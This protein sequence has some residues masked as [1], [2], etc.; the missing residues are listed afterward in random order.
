MTF[1]LED[2]GMK[3]IF[4]S[5][6]LPIAAC[7][8]L[9]MLT[10]TA[11]A[12]V[13]PNWIE[14][15]GIRWTF[16]KNLSL[17][18][19]GDTYQYG[20]FVNGDYWV[21]GP[22]NIISIS[23]E[24]V[25]LSEDTPCP[26]IPT[27]TMSA[28]RSINGSMLNPD[29]GGSQGYDSDAGGY[30]AE[31]NVAL[32]VSESTPLSITTGSLVS[33]V[34]RVSTNEGS[35]AARVWKASVL[36]VVSEAPATGSFRPPY[37]GSDKTS[38]FNED[39]LDYSLLSNLQPVSGTP[40]LADLA[41]DFKKL[42]LD[43]KNGWST[44]QIH[45]KENMPTY[46]RELSNKVGVAALALHTR[47]NEDDEQSNALKRDLMIGFV[48]YGIDSFGLISNGGKSLWIADGGHGA[49]RKW[50]ILFAGLVLNDADMMA[51]GEKSGSYRY[52]GE[53]GPGNLPPDFVNFQEDDT[54]FYV[55]ESDVYEPPYEFYYTHTKY[56]NH[57]SVIVTNGSNVV[58][59]VNTSWTAD[60]LE[61]RLYFAVR[62][63]P[64]VG[65]SM[66]ALLGTDPEGS[67][68]DCRGG[69]DFR[70]IGYD[71]DN[72]QLFLG[73]ES[74]NPKNFDGY[75]GEYTEY[76]ISEHVIFG[77]GDISKRH[78]FVEF[79][80]DDVGIPYWGIRY[81][82]DP[83][84]AGRQWDRSYIWIGKS[85]AGYVL[86]ARIMNAAVNVKY[87][88]T[89]QQLWN[90]DA[91][92]DYLDRYMTYLDGDYV[93]GSKWVFDM[94]DA[95]RGDYGPIWPET[96]G[97][98]TVQHNLGVEYD[99]QRGTVTPDSGQYPTGS[100]VVL[101]AQANDGY[102]FVGWGGDE[103][104]IEPSVTITMDEDKTILAL[105]EPIEYAPVAQQLA[106]LPLTEAVN[107][108][109]SDLSVNMHTATAE[110]NVT[111]ESGMGARFDGSD[112]YLRV[113]DADSLGM[114]EPMTISVW[115]CPMGPTPYAK[116]IVK[117][118]AAY[119]SPWEMYAI[120][121]GS[122]GDTPRFVVTDGIAGG[123]IVIAA[124]RNVKL[125]TGQWHHLVAVY[126]GQSIALYL[127][128]SLVAQES[129]PF[130]IGTNHE[131][132]CIG[133]RMGLNT[134]NGYICDVEIYQGA[135][136]PEQVSGTFS[137]DRNGGLA[138]HWLFERPYMAEVANETGGQPAQLIGE[139]EWGEG[140]A[141]EYFVRLNSGKQAV[142]IPLSGCSAEAGT[143]ALWVQPEAAS[144]VANPSALQVLFGHAVSS[145]AN[146]ITLYTVE[147][148]DG[149][150]NTIH[151][152]AIGLGDNAALSDNIAQLIPGRLYH[153]A[154]TWD[155]TTYAVFVDGL[156]QD[157]GT[158]SGLTHLEAFADVGN[159]GTDS[160]RAY[161]SGF[162]GIVDEIQLYRRALNAEEITRLFL[163]HTAKENRLIE[164][165]VYGTDDAGSPI[166]YTAK[167]L[168]AGATFDAQ[169][170]TFFWRPALYQSAGN[171]EIVFAADGY[172]DQKI[173]VSVQDTE[174]AGWYI[175]FLE[176]RGLH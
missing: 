53:Y 47:W 38:Y 41:Q 97:K 36:T 136:T 168:P 98:R 158:F 55:K 8:L 49:G 146:R 128:S 153:I 79:I 33:T 39:Q 117:P 19:A 67:R 28:G 166:Y 9:L 52:T 114:Q 50:P 96:S 174:L 127:D 143:I 175:K 160:G 129:V 84:T 88:S 108:Q 99:L 29:P 44:G 51:I 113:A 172:P 110:G 60:K 145:D 163:T 134:F 82:R 30:S 23:P 74:L 48:Q 57:G 81:A 173:T 100:E 18:G 35:D 93:Q 147:S 10:T 13:G 150:G 37:T 111:F 27:R 16:D 176:S 58:Q 140:W 15:W 159:L 17:D 85:F 141:A 169:K 130:Q 61:G 171:Y 11:S 4:Y 32:G 64:E 133:G 80:S 75:S 144:S 14:Q 2:C 5:G 34:S 92:F 90:H 124:N 7:S 20:Q 132:L 156:Q 165:A 122:S 161:A 21:I 109:I 76:V 86:A 105:F 137:H 94:W 68:Y 120:D 59:G 121:L 31:L 83:R 3:T 71:I 125:Q 162:C 164:F 103:T 73:D 167:N 151:K 45:P 106:H 149:D 107:G 138:G 46:G 126:D 155:G 12:E 78:D 91:L 6:R 112:G 77:H 54:T 123:R 157:T 62:Y 42:W 65:Y 148:T 142:Q 152:L 118:V 154:L 40:V 102:R 66:R 25:V 101:Y 95:Y 1:K 139:P 22:V 115:I 70:I 72:Q 63:G 116:L 170:Q 56:A 89:V 87:G 135:F 69:Y 43:H 24:T 104:G 119:A 26:D 131:P